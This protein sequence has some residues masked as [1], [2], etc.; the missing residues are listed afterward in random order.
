MT[1]PRNVYH[2]END[3]VF[4]GLNVNKGIEQPDIVNVD[5]VHRF[6]KK[7]QRK[8]LSVDEYCQGILSGQ[9]YDIKQGSYVD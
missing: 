4:V 9:P 5:S 7:N 1:K 6:L 2:P 8:E 3:P